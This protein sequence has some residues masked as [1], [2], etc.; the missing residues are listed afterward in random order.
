[1][2]SNDLKERGVSAF[3]APAVWRVA[4]PAVALV[5]ALAATTLPA[6]HPAQATPAAQSERSE[7]PVRSALVAPSAVTDLATPAET[8]RSRLAEA[9]LEIDF[10]PKVA[11]QL[12]QEAQEAFKIL[13]PAFESSG[14][15]GESDE[16]ATETVENSAQRVQMVQTALEQAKTAA[17]E[18][19]EPALLRASAMAWTTVL[20]EA[21]QRLEQS[22]QTGNAAEARRWLA[23]REYRLASPLSRLGADATDAIEEMA[24]GEITPEQALQTV[25]AD[26]LDGY[27]SRMND[28]LRELQNADARGFKTLSAE[29]KALAKGYFRLLEPAYREQRGTEATQKMHQH[30]QNL[31]A[32]FD[33]VEQ[34]FSGFRAAPLSKRER[35]ART[36]QVLRFLSLVSVEYGRGVK[37]NGSEVVVLQEVE[38]N[39]ARTF[40]TG[41][42]SAFSDVAPL[43]D[44]QEQASK[45]GRGLKDLNTTIA[46]D[47]MKK[48]LL[49]PKV[50]DQ[51]VQDLLSEAKDIFPAEW[52][53]TDAKADLD[54]IRTQ[55]DAVV[56]AAQS[57]EWQA[58]E[59][60]RLDA[61]SLLESGTEARIAVFN[62]E[63]KVKLESLIWNGNDPE[64]LASL[65]RKKAD[66]SAFKTTRAELDRTLKKVGKIL[67]KEVAPAAVAT[68]AGIIVFREGLEA[69]LILAALMGSLRK[70]AM[71]KLRRP[72]WLGAGLAFVATGITWFIMQGA[73]TLL[74][75]YGTKLEAIVSLIAIGVLLLIMNWF[76]HQVYWT[77][78]MAAFQKHKH[79]LTHSPT[80]M[81]AQWWGL[82]ILGFTSIYREGFETVLFLQSLVL[83]AGS[84]TVL[85]GAA[86]GFSAV[87]GIGLLVFRLQAKL[88]MKKL[89]IWTGL[90]ICAV[91]GVMVGNTVHTLQLVAWLPVHPL[92]IELP[93]WLGLWFG[94][95][96]TWEGIALQ[97]LSMV[98]VVGS[99]FAAETMKKRELQQKRQS[100]IAKA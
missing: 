32:S 47:T 66:V 1:M 43:L 26:V 68:N 39:E 90:L 36:A 99:F 59:T 94:L 96:P 40:L 30:L 93:A 41:A 98:L 84:A 50:I 95:H 31:P 49:G 85:S 9:A 65:I 42:I 22:V 34:A 80:A 57:G 10:D 29:K 86:I 78:R 54:V 5:L 2:L 92:P 27:Q 33:E 35:N 55:F 7:Q 51:R 19:D 71:V 76:F 61:Y 3:W 62:P 38:V 44:D 37:E 91:L 21:T 81:N 97:V 20:R 88:P 6:L 56:A 12:V 72:M 46:P 53:K 28:A 52:Q 63:L 87:V 15:S 16:S 64:G 70:G 58:A 89:L 4:K 79:E 100:S 14:E 45:L 13:A 8:M 17:S 82:A 18:G 25:H 77:D 69:V 11:T 73:L 74:G 48:Q 83:Q 23:L 24:A 67:G 75:Q 60:A